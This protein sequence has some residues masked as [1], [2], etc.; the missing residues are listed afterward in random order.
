[1][2]SLISLRLNDELLQATKDNA[3]ALQLSQTEYIR[4]AIERMNS[5][6]QRKQ[7]NARLKKASLHV[8]EQ[9]MNINSEFSEIEHDPDA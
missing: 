9:S 5:A 6:T 2:T 4:R 7:R 8:R 1:M 3:H